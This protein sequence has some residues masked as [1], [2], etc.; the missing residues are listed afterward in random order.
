M[1]QADR[2]QAVAAVIFGEEELQEGIAQL[3]DMQSGEQ[4]EVAFDRLAEALA[5]YKH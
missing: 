3:R 5:S 1:K 2:L 4:R